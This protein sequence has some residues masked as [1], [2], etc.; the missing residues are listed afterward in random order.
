MEAGAWVDVARRKFARSARSLRGERGPYPLDAGE[1]HDD[2]QLYFVTSISSGRRGAMGHAIHSPITRCLNRTIHAAAEFHGSRR[3]VAGAGGISRKLKFGKSERKS[4]SRSTIGARTSERRPAQI[5]RRI[6]QIKHLAGGPHRSPGN[7][8]GADR[9][10][11]RENNR[12]RLQ[13][14]LNIGAGTLAPAPFQI[15]RCTNRIPQLEAEALGRRQKLADAKFGLSPF[16][17]EIWDTY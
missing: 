10:Y 7:L 6:P 9:S 11:R 13:L 12:S 16:G 5:T 8:T 17:S 2:T 1:L 15:A 4:E 3:G 14:I